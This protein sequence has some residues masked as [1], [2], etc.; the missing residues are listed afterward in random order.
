MKK[1]CAFI[2]LSFCL[3]VILYT[4]EPVTLKFST[5]V[6]KNDN[7][8]N[9]TLC[10]YADPGQAGEK[11]LWD[12][13]GLVATKRFT[14]HVKNSTFT[15]NTT[16]FPDANTVLS[17]FSNN[18]YFNITDDR[19]EQIGYA[20]NNNEII[21]KF[22]KPIIKLAFPFTLGDILSG[23]FHGTY[24]SGSL[25]GKISGT[26]DVEADGYGQLILPNNVIV[27]N[28]LRVKTTKKYQLV[29]N[30]NP[31]DVICE[32]YRWYGEFNRYPLLVLISL[33][34]E[35]ESSKPHISYYAAYNNKIVRADP[36]LES[37]TNNSGFEFYPN[38]V[39]NE[40]KIKFILDKE[41]LADFEIYDNGGHFIKTLLHE[42]RDAGEYLMEFNT[43]EL[44]LDRGTYY[45]KARIN[46]EIVTKKFVILE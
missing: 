34:S 7:N 17:E 19:I 37:N 14:G 20:S 22:D 40:I 26:Y 46:N 30:N 1:I 10:K 13:S 44:N 2:I 11:M 33:Q 6:I 4:Q 31:Q 28:T 23:S 9:M 21:I 45:I 15:K 32:T 38:P 25:E 35:Y 24:L 43:R 42:K 39:L 18:F 12:Y 3:S 36:L 5:H 41:G 16:L 8:N 29:L 27:K